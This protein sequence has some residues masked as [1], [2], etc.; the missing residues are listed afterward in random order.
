MVFKLNIGHKGKSWK[1]EL[2]DEGLSGKSVGDTIKGDDVKSELAGYELLIT[3]GSDNAGFPMFKEVD[4]VG[5]KRVLLTKGKGMRETKAGLRKRKTGYMGRRS[6][7]RRMEDIQA[8][9]RTQ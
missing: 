6:S 9:S 5:L 1:L 7:R 3:G 8:G 2:A 4:G